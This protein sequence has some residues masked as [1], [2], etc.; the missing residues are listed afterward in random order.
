MTSFAY[1]N[2][3]APLRFQ[4]RS[5]AMLVSALL[6][7]N[8]THT[9]LLNSWVLNHRRSLIHYSSRSL[10]LARTA[11]SQTAC[12]WQHF[13][14]P[15]A[16]LNG[17]TQAR[18]LDHLHFAA[19][20]AAELRASVRCICHR[21]GWWDDG[22]E[23]VLRIEWISVKQQEVTAGRSSWIK[24]TVPTFRFAEFS[25]RFSDLCWENDWRMFAGRQCVLHS[26]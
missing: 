10:S 1:I 8:Q 11:L 25:C 17:R 5:D 15:N 23:A 20:L 13:G 18:I 26:V 4:L 19:G 14:N 7:P 22:L 12:A 24:A 2:I 6:N 3:V 21:A 9:P 16:K